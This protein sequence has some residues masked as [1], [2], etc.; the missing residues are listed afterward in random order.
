MAELCE[1]GCIGFSDDGSSVGNS[2]LLLLAMRT[3]K[4]LGVP[5]I[6]HCEDPELAAGGQMNEGWVSARLGLAGIPAAAEESIVSRDIALCEMTGARLHLTH[7][8]TRGSA[9]LIRNARQKG[10]P[11]TAD[12]TPH[13]L[14]LTEERVIGRKTA[15][16]YH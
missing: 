9:E 2:R 7:I 14:T 15:R 11:V 16:E 6:E 4:T 8:S 12:V 1:A 5:I 10:L 3:S 13:H